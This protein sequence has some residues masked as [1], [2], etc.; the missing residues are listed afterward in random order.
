MFAIYLSTFNFSFFSH[1]SSF[2]LIF[3]CCR[4]LP[5]LF[6]PTSPFLSSFLLHIPSLPCRLT[7]FLL[8]LFTLFSFFLPTHPPL[9]LLFCLLPLFLPSLFG[10]GVSLACCWYC[11]CSVYLKC[12]SL[13]CFLNYPNNVKKFIVFEFWRNALCQFKNWFCIKNWQRYSSSK[14]NNSFWSPLMTLHAH[15]QK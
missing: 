3:F 15:I 2:L 14:W 9:P 1:F 8:V 6:F 12:S 13:R 10:G 11:S 5:F 4:P 7:P